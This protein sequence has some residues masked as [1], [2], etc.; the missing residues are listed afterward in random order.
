[1]TSAYYILTIL[2][3]GIN[4]RWQYAIP[5]HEAP[6]FSVGAQKYEN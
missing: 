2:M 5:K 6:V 4:Y 1:M 3:L